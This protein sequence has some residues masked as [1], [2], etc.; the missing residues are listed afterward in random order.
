MGIF[1]R[2]Q[3]NKKLA[4]FKCSICGKIHD[5]LPALGFMSP[6]YYEILDKK[7]KEEIAELSSDFCVINHE[8]QTD[9]FIRTTLTVPINDV[10][11]DLDY[12]I[13][14]SLSEKSFNEYQT[15]FK[16]NVEGKTYFGMISN[17]IPD[18]EESTLGL[19]VN[20][21]VQGGG[22]RPQITLH[23]IDHKLISDLE[24]GISIQEAEKRIERMKNALHDN[25]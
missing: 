8:N 14:V 18:Y 13:W 5:E 12:G 21:N 1:S 20:V 23:R 7:D 11:Q 2:F 17:E 25:Q 19:H 15:E 10:C 3:K 4:E 22:I 24:N 16:N 6:L 9:R